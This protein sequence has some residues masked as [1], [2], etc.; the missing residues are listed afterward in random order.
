[1]NLGDVFAW[2]A[3]FPI[4]LL[5][6]AAWVFFR[7]FDRLR[8]R[9]LARVV[10]PRVGA[11][12]SE[13]SERKRTLRRGLLV[14]A[15]ALALLAALQPLGGKS[16]HGVE[17]RGVDILVCLDVSRSMLA[18]DLMPSRLERAR[19]EIRELAEGARGDRFGLVAF[20]GSP[21]L[22]APLTRDADSF[23]EIVDLADPLSVSRGGTD[24]GAALEA[25]LVALGDAKGEHEVVLLLTD[26]EDLQGRG[27]R[28]AAACK[29]RG[30]TVH[31]VGFGSAR[32][33]KIPVEED[34]VETFLKDASGSEV[35]SVMDAKS[36]RAV[37]ETTGGVFVSAAGKAR[38]LSDLYERRI[39]PMA[40]KAFAGGGGDSRGNR[41]QWP[42]LG[43]YL[44]WVLEMCLT[45]RR[46]P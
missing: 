42:L 23:T 41:F 28:M 4:L 46:R 3:G 6:P 31:C 32:G 27:R 9:R 7:T 43:A 14:A 29:A 45:D 16:V 37:A 33:G 34:G 1:M 18:R 38:T 22:M 26:G 24:L 17:R 40:K 35:V 11:L 20:A 5:V 10:G 12:T 36:L 30:I 8:A 44:L 15:L 19:R 13:L 2:P 25:A 21:R 39:L